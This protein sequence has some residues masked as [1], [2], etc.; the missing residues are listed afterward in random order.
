MKENPKLPSSFIQNNPW[1][2]KSHPIWPATSFNLKRNIA[3]FNFPSRLAKE[4]LNRL[5]PLLTNAHQ[6]ILGKENVQF[7]PA[8]ELAALDKEFLFEH[9]LC[10]EGFQNAD[11]GQGM[12]VALEGH[13][14]ALFN[15]RNHITLQWVDCCDAWEDTWGQLARLESE[16]GR[17]LAYAFSPKF[18]YL[19]S[20]ME[21]C[22]TALTVCAYLHVPALNHT[23]QIPALLH[24]LEEVRATGMEGTGEHL[25]GDFLLVKNAFTLGVSEEGILRSVHLAATKVVG[26]ESAARSKMVKENDVVVKDLISR[27]Y[28]LLIHSYQLNTRETLTALSM[29]KLGID[30]GWIVGLTDEEANAIFLQVRRAHLLL[31]LQHSGEQSV[32]EDQQAVQ[33]QRAA[34]IHKRLKDVQLKEALL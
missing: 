9:F 25:L 14:L 1:Q 18:G 33:R 10:E 23:G 3:R 29:I 34:F 17:E 6:Q 24:N 19:T 28:G 21:N 27:A 5:L 8:E 26:A 13:F 16:I 22:G 2:K 11:K 31:H 32:G 7:F 30:L 20:Q 12:I 4:E 15:I